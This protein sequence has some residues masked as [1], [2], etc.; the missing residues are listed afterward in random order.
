MTMLVQLDPVTFWTEQAKIHKR[1][2]KDCKPGTAQQRY[3]ENEAMECERKAAEAAA[4][5]AFPKRGT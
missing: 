4:A 5:H 3:H 2:A 1:Y